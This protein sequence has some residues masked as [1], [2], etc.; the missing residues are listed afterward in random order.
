VLGQ[1]N[2]LIQEKDMTAAAKKTATSTKATKKPAA[3]KTALKVVPP[4]GNSGI[5]AP[6]KHGFNGRKVK[7]V[8][9]AIENRKLPAQAKIIL[10]TIEALGG[11]ATQ[12]EI[13]DN[14]LANGLKTVQTPKRIYTFYRAML[15]TDEY[16]T[17]S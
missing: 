10:D 7:L 4:V 1:R 12:G 8:T 14:L 6:A 16:I 3:K 15:E 2:S 5:P 11:E 17:L 13:V 9:K